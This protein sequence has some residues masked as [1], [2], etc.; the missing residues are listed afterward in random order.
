MAVV[1]DATIGGTDSNSYVT[2]SE[3]EIYFN[4]RPFPTNWL[5]LSDDIKSQYLIYS[6]T[7]LD[8]MLVPYGTIASDTQ[9][10]NFPREDI[11]DCN[12][13]LI[14][15]DVIPND[16]KIAQ[17]EQAIYLYSS[18]DITS[19]PSLLT[20]GFKSAKVGDLSITVDKLNVANK[21]A[22]QTINFLRCYGIISSGATSGLSMVQTY[23]N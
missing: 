4:N 23:R 8:N 5:S 10:L 22:D 15:N 2:L 20:K 1:I 12:N 17:M 9:T 3:S 14:A 13:R 16:I 11:H 21:L 6:T 18:G 19:K 7:M